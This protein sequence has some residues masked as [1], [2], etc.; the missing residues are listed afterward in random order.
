[1]KGTFF[2]KP[3]EFSLRVEGESW[4]QGEA[5]AGTLF[6]KNHGAQAL[7]GGFQ[8]KLA[9]GTLKK[10]HQKVSGAFYEILATSSAPA[11]EIAPQA[12]LG[13]SWRFQTDRNCPITDNT[14][15]L[16]LLYGSE[17]ETEKMG[18]LQVTIKP[19]PVIEEFLKA[20]QIEFRFVVKSFKSSKR[21][22]D[23]KLMPPDSQHFTMLDYAQL[24]FRFDGDVLHVGYVFNLKE[25]Q[26]S[27]AAVDVKKKKKEFEQTFAP[28]EYRLSSGRF[29]HE[30]LEAAAA[31]AI[32]Q[33]EGKTLF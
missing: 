14:E 33:V 20:F 7:P 6:A 13:H 15:S 19:E 27:S 8:V 4:R 26:A 25:V 9:R 10:V 21:G 29:N 32:K 17:S 23:V 28:G 11:G 3:L 5:I 12:E 24:S 18:H 16:F 31:E 30:R 1:M 22:V 2:Q